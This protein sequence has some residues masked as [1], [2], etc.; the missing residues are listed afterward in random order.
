MDNTAA[1]PV[2]KV[3]DVIS[4][5]H[6]EILTPNAIRLYEACWHRMRV[7]GQ[8]Q[9]W[10]DDPEASIRSRTLIGFIPA[11]RCELINAGLLE[12]WQGTQQWKY[13][14][15]EQTEPNEEETAS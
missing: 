1:K 14:Y 15:I 3:E 4:E 9:V 8:T 7:K 13:T 6:R 5:F 12:C 11:A 2:V 10:M